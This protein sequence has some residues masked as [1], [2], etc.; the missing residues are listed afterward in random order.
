M[1]K[2][3]KNKSEKY[4][5]DILSGKKVVGKWARLAIE[6]HADDLKNGHKRGLC[7]DEDAGQDIIDFFKLLN[8]SKGEWAGTPIILEDWQE[9]ILRV[10]FGWM[11]ENGTRR[12]RTAYNEIPKKNGKSTLAA[13]VALYLLVADDEPG[14]E[15]YSTATKVDQARIVWTEARNMVKQ[16]KELR[17]E[18]SIMTKNLHVISTD[19]KF[20]PLASDTKTLDGI[21]IH[22][23]IVDEL[24]AHKNPD[25][26]NVIESGGASRR[27]PLQFEITTAGNRK[28]SIGFDHH[29]YSEKILEGVVED[30]SWFAIIYCLD[31]NIDKGKRDKKGNIIYEDDDW[32]DPKVWEKVNPNYGISVK[33]DQFSSL[34]KKAKE[35]PASETIFRQLRLNQWVEQFNRWIHLELWDQNINEF[36]PEILEGRDCYGGLD[37]AKTMDISALALI[38]PPF[39][40]EK[41]WRLL[42]HY[43]VPRDNILTR[44]RNDHVP[45]DLWVKRG[46]IFST[47][48]NATDYRFIRDEIKNEI[49]PKYKIREIAFDRMFANE[50][51]QDLQDEGLE[52]V[53]FG[54]GFYSMSKPTFEMERLLLARELAHN[55]D[56]VLRWMASNVVVKKDP[57]GNLKPDKE[58]S[59][60]K[61]DGIVALIMAIGRAM[62]REENPDSVYEG[63]GI[64]IL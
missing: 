4:I 22:G 41:I 5:A 17:A 42:M 45:Y 6:R 54:Q 25:M 1:A 9:F 60:E 57:A 38:F 58:K 55:G 23:A 20:E 27:Q 39:E 48:G 40:D 30:D 13:G 59:E 49:A 43:W 34:Y 63:R 53:E 11:R 12:F 16:S 46:L 2:K 36:D 14:A 24:H 3:P 35:L 10:I 62:V 47:P 8:H 37:L 51:T 52:M 44:V 56:E 7:F 29:S 19:S 31:Q 28:F 50:L 26:I 21:N 32:A 64:L 33:A 18:I 15:I 61:I